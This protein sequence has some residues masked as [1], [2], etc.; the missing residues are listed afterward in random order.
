MPAGREERVG[1]QLF[2]QRHIQGTAKDVIEDDAVVAVVQLAESLWLGFGPF[3]QLGFV[4][5]RPKQTAR[6]T[7][8]LNLFRHAGQSSAVNSAKRTAD[9]PTSFADR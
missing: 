3:N 2:G 9:T 8:V 1:A 7:D 6:R 5:P 4:A